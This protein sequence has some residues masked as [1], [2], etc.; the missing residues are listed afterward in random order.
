MQYWH[1]VSNV[2]QFIKAERTG[3]FQS[4]LQSMQ[5]MLLYSYSR[6][7]YVY[8][9]SC[10]LYLQHILDLEDKLWPDEYYQFAKQHFFT[11]RRSD[12]FWSGIFTDQTIEQVVMRFLKAQ[13]SCYMN[14]AYAQYSGA[15]G[16]H[17]PNHHGNF[18][19]SGNFCYVTYGTSEQHV[20]ARLT[21]VQKIEI[22][23][24]CN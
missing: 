9:R 22:C 12:K 17:H 6:G 10:Q 13:G 2:K 5:Q 24:L 8:A 14:E 7:P 4:H 20:D 18:R 19:T 16:C 11:I 21:R 15:L 3:N 23:V 1:T